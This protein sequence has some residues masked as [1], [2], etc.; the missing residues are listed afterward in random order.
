MR[1]I[2][3]WSLAYRLDTGLYMMDP[4]ENVLF[5]ELRERARRAPAM[6][7]RQPARGST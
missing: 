6:P 5:S 3:D 4:W 2:K 1:T 7:C